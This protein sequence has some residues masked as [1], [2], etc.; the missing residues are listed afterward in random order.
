MKK[1]NQLEQGVETCSDALLSRAQKGDLLAFEV[2]VER[3]RDRLYSFARRIT[4][5]ETDGLE[6][7]QECFLSAHSHLRNFRT[8]AQLSTWL[9]RIAARQGSV[10][11][12]PR[13]QVEA[14][15]QKL[16]SPKFHSNGALSHL[17]SPRW[18]GANERA[19]SP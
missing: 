11:F 18:S 8:V 19:L 16:E 1:Q 17:P 3:H 6:I 10:R 7:A 5:S 9:Y 12:L 15:A 13:R 14:K 2:L 4:Q